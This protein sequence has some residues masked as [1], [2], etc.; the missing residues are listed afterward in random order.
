MNAEQPRHKNSPRQKEDDQQHKD[1]DLN[2][3]PGRPEAAEAHNH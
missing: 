3:Q 1:K 2:Q